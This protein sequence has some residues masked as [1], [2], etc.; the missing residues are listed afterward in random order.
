MQ[1]PRFAVAPLTF[2]AQLVKAA[3]GLDAWSRPNHDASLKR[4]AD[5]I[6]PRE[7]LG[8]KTYYSHR[9]GRWALFRAGTR[10]E[11]Y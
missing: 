6:S 7:S 1:K 8:K 9:T 5:V 4:A 2:G 3:T 10:Y 11:N